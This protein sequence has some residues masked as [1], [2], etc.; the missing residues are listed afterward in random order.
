MLCVDTWR[1]LDECCGVGRSLR[2]LMIR[3]EFEHYIIRR[4]GNKKI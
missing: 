1:I 3:Y 2:I 4:F